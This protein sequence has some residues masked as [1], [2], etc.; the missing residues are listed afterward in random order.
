MD[1]KANFKISKYK[2]FWNRINNTPLIGYSTGSYFISKRFNAASKFLRESKQIYPDMINALDFKNDY[3]RMAEEYEKF[4]EDTIFT[5]VPFTGLPWMEAI[6]GCEISSTESSFVAHSQDTDVNHF[7]IEKAFN[8]NWYEKYMEFTCMLSEIGKDIF[9]V[10]QPIM[11]GP[12]DIAGTILGQGQLVYDFYDYPEKVVR[13]MNDSVDIFLDIIKEQKSKIDSFYG[14]SSIGFYDLWCP[15]EC[16]WYQDDLNALL[17][18]EIYEKYVYDIHKRIC[19]SYEYSLIHL[20]PASFYIV[21]YLLQIDELSAIQINKDVGGPSVEEM[22]LVF[23]KVQEKKNLI[24]WGDFNREEMGI[25]TKN[26]KPEGLYIIIFS[27][28]FE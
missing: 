25:L 4:N 17:S 22:I 14:G 26:L 7:D 21:D 1:N 15:G 16:I 27:E 23:Q 3:V 28:K 12:T 6:L 20:H 19:K 13:L 24:V 18:P 5:G 8:K 10:G 9:P 2:E 11:R